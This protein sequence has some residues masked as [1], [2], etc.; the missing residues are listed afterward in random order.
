MPSA[1]CTGASAKTGSLAASEVVAWPVLSIRSHRLSD[2]GADEPSFTCGQSW[3]ARTFSKVNVSSVRP[4]MNTT[5]MPSRVAAVERTASIA[6]SVWSGREGTVG[7]FP[8][9][10]RLRDPRRAWAA[11]CAASRSLTC[12]RLVLV[13]ALPSANTT[14]GTVW[15]PPLTL[16]T[17]SAADG[18]CSMSTTS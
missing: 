12:P 14:V 3:V 7:C 10:G 2:R 17:Y 13:I 16:I 6:G 4:P 5:S 18:S 9:R 15:L 1:F 8:G 11:G